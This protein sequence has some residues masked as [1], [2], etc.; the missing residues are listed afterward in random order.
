MTPLQHASTAD[1]IMESLGRLAPSH[2]EMAIEAAMLAGTHMLN[3]VLH[4]KGITPADADVLHAEY[5]T[6]ALRTRV[7]LSLPGLV[8]ALDEIEQMRPLFVR[9][10]VDGG[11]AAADRALELFAFIRRMAE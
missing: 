10:S 4:L 1:R 7:Q 8:E 3:A 5:M 9:G 6:L 2:H 11:Q